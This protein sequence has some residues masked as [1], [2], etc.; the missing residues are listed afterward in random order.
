MNLQNI[1]AILF[2]SK[3]FIFLFLLFRLSPE[4]WQNWVV[5]SLTILVGVLVGS[6]YQ[7]I[8]KIFL[9]YLANKNAT[10]SLIGELKNIRSAKA[11]LRSVF[12]DNDQDTKSPLSGISLT[13]V[14]VCLGVYVLGSSTSLFGWAIVSSLWSQVIIQQFYSST[15]GKTAFWTYPF[16]QAISGRNFKIFIFAQLLLF[17]FMFCI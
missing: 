16:E 8:N 1:S 12:T 14:I 15:T 10:K 5:Y 17:L 13:V 11:I 9:Y 7:L 4:S 6:S 2:F 3:L